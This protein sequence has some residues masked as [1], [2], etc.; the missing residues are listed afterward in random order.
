MGARRNGK[1]SG[2]VVWSLRFVVE[3]E[4][5]S[6]NL[7]ADYDVSVIFPNRF[8]EDEDIANNFLFNADRWVFLSCTEGS[9]FLMCCLGCYRYPFIIEGLLHNI[10]VQI[11]N[12]LEFN[13][14]TRY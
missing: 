1:A 12:S 14:G 2:S 8:L 3:L 7:R 11:P 9:L 4:L 13:F 6:L 5:C 10:I